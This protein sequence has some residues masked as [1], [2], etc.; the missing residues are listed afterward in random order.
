MN[1]MIKSVEWLGD[2]EDSSLYQLEEE[3]IWL[4]KIRD[5]HH[6]SW[7]THSWKETT[8]HTIQMISDLSITNLYPLVSLAFY[9]T[10][11]KI[12]QK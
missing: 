5:K 12:N 9:R 3:D 7:L 11:I 2:S 8:S 4:I 10:H 6:G 1:M